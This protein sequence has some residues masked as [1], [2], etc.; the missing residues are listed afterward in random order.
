MRIFVSTTRLLIKE[1]GMGKASTSI[2]H[3][4]DKE[5]IQ[6]FSRRSERKKVI[7]RPRRRLED[8]IKKGRKDVGRE[9]VDRVLLGFSGRLF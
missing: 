5:Y 4:S 9:N 8:N 7:R 3:G 1:D 6:D 2:T